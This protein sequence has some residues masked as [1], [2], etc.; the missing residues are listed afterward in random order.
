MRSLISRLWFSAA[1]IGVSEQFTFG[2]KVKIRLLNKVFM[3]GILCAVSMLP[4]AVNAPDPIR[5]LL[6][7]GAFIF[8]QSLVIFLHHLGYIKFARYF[9]SFIFPTITASLMIYT[10]AHFG[11]GYIFVLSIFMTFILYNHQLVVRN[12]LIGLKLLIYLSAAAYVFFTEGPIMD[13]SSLDEHLVFVMCIFAMGLIILLYQKELNKNQARQQTLIDQLRDKNEEL[14][15]TN[16]ELERFTYIAS[17]D[18]KSPL[19][20]IINFLEV[21]EHNIK[22]KEFSNLNEKLRHVKTS[23]KQMNYV[24]TDILEYSSINNTPLEKSSVDLNEVVERVKINLQN[25]IEAKGAVVQSATLP[26]IFANEIEFITVFQNLVENGLKYNTSEKPKINISIEFMEDKFVL[27]FRDN[28]IGID[29]KYHSKI[30]ELFQR[31]HHET[32][33]EGTGLGLGICAKIIKMYQGDI[34]VE[35]S[36]GE[37][38]VFN[39]QLSND[40]LIMSNGQQT[41]EEKSSEVVSS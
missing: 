29:N 27:K 1:E 24:V 14:S 3:L 13:S 15:D 25:D 5:Y 38:S 28:G 2:E 41:K 36:L 30:F 7:I 17:H 11:E 33:Y 39:I 9:S 35:S 37:G 16:E 4:L 31:L 21:M 40:L 26:T 12:V 23:A 32:T 22:K 6:E 34:W 18:L 10:R 19:R 20:R 8:V